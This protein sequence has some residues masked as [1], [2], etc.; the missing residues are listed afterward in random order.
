MGDETEKKDTERSPAQ[1]TEQRARAVI[2]DLRAGKVWR[3]TVDDVM[4]A[5]TRAK[6][7]AAVSGGFRR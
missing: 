4:D 1:Q 2:D 5:A 7:D 3:Q 6:R